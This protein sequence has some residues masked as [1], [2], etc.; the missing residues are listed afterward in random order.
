MRSRFRQFRFLN[1]ERFDTIL[2]R[3]Q[4]KSIEL[5]RY[6]FLRCGFVLFSFES[7][8]LSVDGYRRNGAAAPE[9]PWRNR[10]S[11]STR[12]FRSANSETTPAIQ[13]PTLTGM[14][15]PV[16]SARVIS[17]SR[18][19][20]RNDSRNCQARRF[21]SRTW[22]GNGNNYE[23]VE[24]KKLSG[25]WFDGVECERLTYPAITQKEPHRPE[26]CL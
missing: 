11:R 6:L 25:L 7:R 26:D 15:Q 12:F 8:S 3:P 24:R 23:R 16:G 18:A 9:L 10:P 21:S 2:V 13:S 14:L 1:P 5:L 17:F 4:T 20:N 19:F 22:G